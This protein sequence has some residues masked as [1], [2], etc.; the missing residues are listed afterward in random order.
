[1]GELSPLSIDHTEQDTYDTKPK[2][3]LNL[4]QAPISQEMRKRKDEARKHSTTF[5]KDQV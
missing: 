3:Q 1:M 2:F 5:S 4:E